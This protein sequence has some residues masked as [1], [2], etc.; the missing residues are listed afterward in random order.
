M[1]VRSMGVRAYE[2]VVKKRRQKKMEK[3]AEAETMVKVQGWN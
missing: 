1:G 3:E 2:R